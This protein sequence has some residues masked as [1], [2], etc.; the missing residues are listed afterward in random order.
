MLY[1]NLSL[2]RPGE[3]AALIAD[4]SART[5]LDVVRVHVHRIDLLRDAAEITIVYKGPKE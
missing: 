1:D 5:G 3:R 4:L 2:L